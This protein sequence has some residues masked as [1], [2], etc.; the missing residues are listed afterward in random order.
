MFLLY[1]DNFFGSFDLD[2]MI[3]PIECWLDQ[4]HLILLFSPIE[5][6]A[7]IQYLGVSSLW[8]TALDMLNLKAGRNSSPSCLR[9]LGPWRLR[10]ESKLDN[11]KIYFLL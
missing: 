9:M 6:P 1:L 7:A 10:G 5:C 4:K 11:L 8:N 2:P 3:M